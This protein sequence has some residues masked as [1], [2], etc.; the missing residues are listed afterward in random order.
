MKELQRHVEQF[1]N[2]RP[3]M[4]DHNTPHYIAER[5]K[6][7]IDEMLAEMSGGER[8]PTPEEIDKVRLELADVVIFAIS[9]AQNLGID[10]EQAVKDKVVI[11]E[12]RFPAEMFKNGDFVTIYQQRKQ[13]LGEL[14]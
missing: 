6:G 2:E 1:F 13:E 3:L 12:A 14:S 10:L 4:R 8:K 9:M 5:M 7:E 11:N